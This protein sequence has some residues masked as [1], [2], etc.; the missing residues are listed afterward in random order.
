MGSQGRQ[1]HVLFFPLL[2]Y[3]HMIPTLDI[4]KL[5]ASRGAKI[6]IVA[7]P[8]NAPTFTR[9]IDQT[10]GEIKVHVYSFPGK[11][12]GLP[13]GVENFDVL[14]DE[15]MINKFLKAIDMLEGTLEQLLEEYKPNCLVAD[16][17]F[18]WATDVASKFNIPR[19]VFH[20]SSFFPFCIWENIRLYEPHKKVS[21]DD[22]EFLV[23]N[24]PHEIRLLRS[25]VP[26]NVF[27]DTDDEATRFLK[28]GLEAEKKSFGIIMNSF[29]ELEPD[30]VD[31]YRNVMGKRAWHI[32]PVSLF[33]R[34]IEDKA[35]RGKKSVI[36]EDECLKWLNSKEPNSVI[37][38]SFGSITKF[39]IAQLHEIAGALESSGQE[40]MWVVRGCKDEDANEE[41]WFPEGF[42]N[43]MQGKGLI[44]KGWAPQM[45]KLDHA[46]TG[47][48]MTHC[49]WNSTLEGISTGVPLVTWP[50]FGEQFYNEKLIVEILK[51]GVPVG[52][53][54]WTQIGEAADIIT[55]EAIASALQRVMQGKEAVEVRRRAMELKD[56]AWKAV[57]EGGSSYRDMSALFQELSQYQA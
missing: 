5:F 50:V 48:F 27:Q 39:S 49:G 10:N 16:L 3:G 56:L 14:T 9:A 28:R 7:T 12:A 18:P 57:Q 34:N 1:L 47:A 38:I 4:A 21:A 53:K 30:Y 31:Y 11:E 13:E 17:F 35:R 22:E 42:E 26:K 44:I 8:L 45:L 51:T 24:L 32:G 20:G 52:N 37:Y 29:Y 25:Q 23:P 33:N 6:T 19:L 15:V 40:F 2:A 46:A 54:K 41:E 43:R 36:D 55:K